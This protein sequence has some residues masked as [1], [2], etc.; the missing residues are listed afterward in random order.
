MIMAA[1][2]CG[3]HLLQ[4]SVGKSA[5][6]T[7]TFVVG[8]PCDHGRSVIPG[9]HASDQAGAAGLWCEHVLLQ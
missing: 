2:A 1:V 9:P 5:L 7:S 6:S 4:L 3:W 8:W